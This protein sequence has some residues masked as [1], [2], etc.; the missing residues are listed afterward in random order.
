MNHE[1][2]HPFD[3][4]CNMPFRRLTRKTKSYYT[5]VKMDPSEERHILD[6]RPLGF[7]DVAVLGRYQYAKAHPALELHSHG[8][9]VEICFLESG[10][11]VYCVGEDTFH[12]SG[13]D[14]F[15]TFPYECHG[16]NRIPQSKGVLYWLLINVPNSN[17]RLLSLSQTESRT[18]IDRLLN[19]PVRQFPG[20]Q[21]IG[22]VLRQL[23]GTFQRDED[24]LR[25]VKLR[26]LLLS[27]LLEVL[28]ASQNADRRVSP[29]IQAVQ[30][31]IAENLDQTLPIRRLA[32]LAHLSESR[33]KARFKAEVGMPPADYAMRQRIDRAKQLF[34]Q[35]DLPVT[36]IAFRLGF[37][38]SQ[39]FATAFK[40]YAGQTPTNYRRQQRTR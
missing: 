1:K 36:E 8:N 29:E 33:F 5:P 18:V 27:F 20:N 2:T 23:I 28:E 9:M 19:L 40:H 13:G 39:Y 10:Q 14:L 6:F 30:R 24:P 7:R 3:S 34:R 4:Y 35:S 11:Q 15:V 21:G 22:R 31:A 16:S 25:L 26:N 38:S 12:L 37:S 32:Q 17:G